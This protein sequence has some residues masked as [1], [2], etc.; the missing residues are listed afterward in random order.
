[1]RDNASQ[2]A[3]LD[4]TYRNIHDVPHTYSSHTLQKYFIILLIS[5]LVERVAQSR[6][7]LI[8]PLVRD[9]AS[10]SISLVMARPETELVGD[11]LM[12]QKLAPG[13]GTGWW[14]NTGT[15]QQVGLSLV[16][17]VEVGRNCQIWTVCDSLLPNS[18]WLLPSVAPRR[19]FAEIL[20]SYLSPLL[21]LM[22]IG[23]RSRFSSYFWEHT[24]THAPHAQAPLVPYPLYLMDRS[25]RDQVDCPV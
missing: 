19:L 22:P 21:P 11:K 3:H 4:E 6:K 13:T 8:S 17:L 1:M 12:V 25:R 18:E 2:Y 7:S 9:L 15:T 5:F 24:G 16:C 20:R 14:D 23:D 10:F